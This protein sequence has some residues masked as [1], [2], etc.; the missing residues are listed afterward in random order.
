[1]SDLERKEGPGPAVEFE[2]RDD[3]VIAISGFAYPKRNHDFDATITVNDT[4]IGNVS[5]NLVDD[6]TLNLNLFTARGRLRFYLQN[7]SEVWVELN[8]LIMS[9]GKYYDGERYLLKQL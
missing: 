6:V 7:G 4:A 9:R 1:M 3:G 8:I 2:T 5:G